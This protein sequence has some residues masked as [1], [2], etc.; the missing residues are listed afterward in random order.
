MIKFNDEQ[1]G[2]VIIYEPEDIACHWIEFGGPK[3]DMSSFRNVSRQDQHVANVIAYRNRRRNHVELLKNRY[4]PLT[5]AHMEIFILTYGEKE[6]IFET[7][8]SRFDI[9]DL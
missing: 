5:E 9:L 3:L 8:D 6:E 2:N 4:G 1:Y 7:I